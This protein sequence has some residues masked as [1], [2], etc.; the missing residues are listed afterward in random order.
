M[1][2]IIATRKVKKNV[3]IIGP[4][5]AGSTGDNIHK[6]PKKIWG[7][8]TLKQ[9]IRFNN[10]YKMFWDSVNYHP[11]MAKDA[12]FDEYRGTLAYNFAL[13]MT[14]DE[15]DRTTKKCRHSFIKA[16][17]VGGGCIFKYCNKCGVTEP[18]D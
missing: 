14:W 16:Q 12:K 8:F 13:L 6:V 15:A 11:E 17:G 5:V 9:H 3:R 2:E 18:L 1:K 7:K 10:L 4:I